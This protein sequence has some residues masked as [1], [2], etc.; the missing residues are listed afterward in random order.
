MFNI[1]YLTE[2]IDRSG[3]SLTAIGKEIG[4]SHSTLSLLIRGISTNPQPETINSLANYFGVPPKALFLNEDDS[5]LQSANIKLASTADTLKYLMQVTGVVNSSQLHRYTDIAIPTIN[6]ILSGQTESPNSQTMIKLAEF[7]NV[8]IPQLK[9]IDPIPKGKLFYTVKTDK[10]IPSITIGHAYEWLQTQNESLIQKYIKTELITLSDKAYSIED[11][12]NPKIIVTFIIEPEME[13]E[14]GDSL[15][16][17]DGNQA[18]VVEF[19]N[20][21]TFLTI[22]HSKIKK[23][24]AHICLGV[25]V[26]ELRQRT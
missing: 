4:I 10:P 13:P 26:Q 16:I 24:D 2:L 1:Q 7:F 18:Q 25:I 3:M 15:I 6:R 22:N 9:G 19:F 8:S 20:K 17:F 5:L 14:I 21:T 11:I 12:T 23:S